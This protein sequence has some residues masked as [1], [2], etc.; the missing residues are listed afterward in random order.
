MVDAMKEMPV[1]AE[2]ATQG[3]NRQVVL[4]KQT[5]SRI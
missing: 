2:A 5:L 1:V 4:K 3:E